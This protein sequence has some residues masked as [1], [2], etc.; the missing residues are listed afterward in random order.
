[1]KNIALGFL[2][3][4]VATVA[5]VSPAE[6][7]GGRSRA[8]AVSNPPGLFNRSVA[9]AS[10]NGGGFASASVGGAFI[11]T[12]NGLAIAS[13]GGF[14]HN[15]FHSRAFVPVAVAPVAIAAVPVHVNTVPV[16]TQ[17]TFV[18]RVAV[19]PVGV[20]V[21]T[22][23]PRY[24]AFGTATAVDGCGNVFESDVFGNSVFRGNRFGSGFIPQ[25]EQLPSPVSSYL[26]QA[27]QLPA[28][29]FS[30]R[31]ETRTVFGQ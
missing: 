30:T 19:A 3:L 12:N 6:A 15:G 10:S 7:I 20:A 24:N 17:T 27:T 4:V 14:H 21:A 28:S 1:M 22:V 25:A 5:L 8:V 9:R 18:P 26:P 13:V 11:P 31:I 23:G 2:S 16:F 29:G